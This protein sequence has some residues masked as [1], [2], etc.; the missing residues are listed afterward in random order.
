MRKTVGETKEALEFMSRIDALDAEA[1][2]HLRKVILQLLDCYDKDD[3]YGVLL[4]SHTGNRPNKLMGLNCDE[5]Q[6]AALL[7]EAAGLM[8]E[9]HAVEQPDKGMLN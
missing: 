1:R 5:M 2:E 6:S 7:Q 9:Y 3:V 4:I 8:L